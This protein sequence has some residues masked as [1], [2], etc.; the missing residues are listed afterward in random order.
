MVYCITQQDVYWYASVCAIIP[1][2]LFQSRYMWYWCELRKQPFEWPRSINAQYADSLLNTATI[3]GHVGGASVCIVVSLVE[4]M[5]PGLTSWYIL[6]LSGLIASVSTLRLAYISRS[7]VSSRITLAIG[8]ILWIVLL[9][10]W[11][12]TSDTGVVVAM[13][14]W[15]MS[16][17]FGRIVY[18]LLYMLPAKCLGSVARDMLEVQGFVICVGITMAATIPIWTGSSH[19]Y[20]TLLV[21]VGGICCVYTLFQEKIL[22][23]RASTVPNKITRNGLSNFETLNASLSRCIGGHLSHYIPAK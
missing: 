1:F 21:C 7:S 14:W 22:H 2:L 16:P 9:V 3:M 13:F 11:V 19:W 12:Y 4:I 18:V 17:T 20:N 6:L 10:L 5:I 15:L 23:I 8:G